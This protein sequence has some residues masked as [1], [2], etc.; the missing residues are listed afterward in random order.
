MF[1]GIAGE[2]LDVLGF[3][4]A[5]DLAAGADDVMRAGLQ[6][7][8]ADGSVDRFGCAV[9]E[10]ADGV[11]VAQEHLVRGHGLAG[12][13]DGGGVIEVDDLGLEPAEM[14]EDG[15]GI[16][17]DVQADHDAERLHLADKQLLGGVDEAL[18]ELGP[19]ERGGRVADAD[20]GRAGRHLGFGKLEFHV[21]DEG[22]Q[23]A[24][25][26]L[27]VVKVEHEGVDATKVGGLGAG[28]LDPAFDN[29]VA[30]DGS[31]ELFDS[32]DAIVHSPGVRVGVLEMQQGG[33]VEEAGVRFVDGGGRV[34]MVDDRSAAV[35][36][37][38]GGI[39]DR[40]DIVERELVGDAELGFDEDAVVGGV[41]QVRFADAVGGELHGDRHQRHLVGR[42]GLDQR[43]HA[44]SRGHA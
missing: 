18:V 21:A 39:R 4:V 44:F 2:G 19:D 29:L 15:R 37:L 24:D 12:R 33:L 3:R 10:R 41:L 6:V 35:G 22:E 27:I 36:R 30:A 17:A 13:V 7:A 11:D 42:A 5:G 1:A 34:G 23:V 26:R 28:A 43:Q 8:M 20:Q 25:E 16:A 38:A 9:A 32:E 40:R 31:G 14:L